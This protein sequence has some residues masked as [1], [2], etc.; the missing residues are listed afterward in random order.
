[1]TLLLVEDNAHIMD[2][3]RE[4][5]IEKG[6]NIIEAET[7]SECREI[8]KKGSPNLILLDI[9]LPDG[10]GLDFCQELRSCSSDAA[11]VPI[12]ILSALDEKEEV[13]AGLKAGG[14][15]Y[16]TKPYDIH[17][18]VT[19]I[20]TL[21]RRV[22]Y[23][24]QN[25]KKLMAADLVCG[26]I[27]IG[28]ISGR[29]YVRNVDL[30]LHKKEFELLSM[31]VQHKDEIIGT[32][33]LYGKIWAVPMGNDSQALRSAISRLRKKIAHSGY[34]ITKKRGGGYCFHKD[35]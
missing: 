17:E 25:A 5:L 15:D 29:A 34:V 7:L 6:Y 1:M 11:H 8:L 4:I 13:I 10:D 20:E 18:L 23:A 32:E 9:L 27:T 3:N 21:L 12:L 24:D 28:R 30:A 26:S 22:H 33:K 2:I 16:L 35:T 31:F 14:D 19:R